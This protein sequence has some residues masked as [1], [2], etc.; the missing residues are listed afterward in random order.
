MLVFVTSY[1]GHPRKASL[2]LALIAAGGFLACKTS[3]PPPATPTENITVAPAASA[4]AS[5][6]AWGSPPVAVEPEPFASHSEPTEL[7]Q[8]EPGP[9][10]P[11]GMAPF[12]RG[13][14]AQAVGQVNLSSCKNAGA[15]TGA[16]HVTIT[17]NPDGSV[18]AAIIDGGPLAGTS[19]GSCVANKYRNAR[20]PPF[21]G[22]AVRI[23]K[24]FMLN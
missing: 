7:T 15:P 4:S 5:T 22:S 12:D 17:F 8:V 6:V 19:A 21:S 14:A 9:T 3:D 23:G 18:A 1:R 10:G 20:V 24:T 11:P 13:A 16:S 2:A